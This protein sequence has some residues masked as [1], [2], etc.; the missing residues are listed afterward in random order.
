MA[1]VLKYDELTLSLSIL[2]VALFLGRKMM[3][4]QSLAHP[5][6]LGRQVEVAPVRKKG[7]SAVYRNFGVGM[8]SPLPTRP[9]TRPCTVLDFMPDDVTEVRT[10]WNTQITNAQLKER[11]KALSLGFLHT[12]GLQP[13]ESN[14]L[15]LLDDSF[16]FLLTDLALASLSIPTLTLTSLPLL[17]PTIET[18]PPTAIVVAFSMLDETLE[19]IHEGEDHT[20]PVIIVVG[21]QNNISPEKSRKSGIK[22]HRWDDLVEGG[23]REGAEDGSDGLDGVQAPAPND[24]FTVTF[25]GLE[26]GQPQGVQLTHVNVTAGVA[27]LQHIFPMSKAFSPDDT[28]L[29]SHSLTTPFGRSMAYT[30]LLKGCNFAT[31]PS[32]SV[33]NPQPPTL[34]E[35]IRASENEQIP[36]PTVLVISTAVFVQVANA[37]LNQAQGNLLYSY[38]RRHK[39]H[40]LNSGTTGKNTIW[41]RLVFDGAR[42]K[43]LGRLGGSLDR[44]LITGDS[45]PSALLIPSRI[46]LPIPTVR[47]CVHPVAAGP[48]LASHPLDLQ[49][50]PDCETAAITLEQTAHLGPP[51]CNVE[52]K[53]VGVDDTVVDDGKVDP[54]GQMYIRGPSLGQAVPPTSERAADGWVKAGL[55]SSVATNGTFKAQAV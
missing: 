48:L 41:D 46:A 15:L 51:T 29:S 49:Y 3:E 7:E 54:V 37:V 47:T 1:S 53:L 36:S 39:Q 24:V 8:G 34:D 32:T 12:A 27:A 40:A 9:L 42:K 25:T 14:V 28:I 16:E 35:L 45:L 52:I 20:V 50:F 17:T 43:A 2:T 19:L 6:L 23:V 30:A 38:A 18:Y 31:L 55:L 11:I 26:N 13:R 4:P 44:V 33:L 10:L 5:M 22:I 21:D